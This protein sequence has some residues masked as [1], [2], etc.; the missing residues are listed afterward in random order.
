ME[1][2]ATTQEY[3]LV[4]SVV[5]L[6]EEVAGVDTPGSGLVPREELGFGIVQE[7]GTEGM[8]RVRW[9]SS[10]LDTWVNIADLIPVDPEAHLLAIYR[11]DEHGRRTLERCKVLATAGLTRNWIAELLPQYIVRTVRSDGKAW[12]FDYYPLIKRTEPLHTILVDALASDDHAEAL[13]VA[14]L[15][16]M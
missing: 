7:I 1:T 10:G 11:V 4:E 8:V 9:P 14:D 12:T 6:A 13:T 3:P 5:T 2:P 16:T 15:A